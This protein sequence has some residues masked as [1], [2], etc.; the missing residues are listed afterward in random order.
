LTLT[1]YEYA[2]SGFRSVTQQWF[3]SCLFRRYLSPWAVEHLDAGGPIRGRALADRIAARR[4]NM[5]EIVKFRHV[6]TR[7]SSVTTRSTAQWYHS[8]MA[9]ASHS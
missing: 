3:L 4:M 7:P 1:R 8:N 9:A 6:I 2:V 5:L